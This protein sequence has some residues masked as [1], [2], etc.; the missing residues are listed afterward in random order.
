M[1]ELGEN[2][3]ASA[4]G[5]AFT[6]PSSTAVKTTMPLGAFTTP[7]VRPRFTLPG[8]PTPIVRVNLAAKPGNQPG[9]PPGFQPWAIGYF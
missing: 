3:P 2:P 4:A 7:P 1:A 9:G 6:S 8:P 5:M